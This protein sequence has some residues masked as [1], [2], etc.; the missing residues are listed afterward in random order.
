MYLTISDHKRINEM[1]DFLNVLIQQT[2]SPIEQ[3]FI[4]AMRRDAITLSLCEWQK[5]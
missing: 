3:E 5:G 4:E 1:V 2:Q